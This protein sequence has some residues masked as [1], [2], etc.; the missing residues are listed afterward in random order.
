MPTFARLSDAELVMRM[1]LLEKHKTHQKAAQALGVSRSSFSTSVDNAKARGLTATTKL[2]N[3]EDRLRQK[4][5][6]A[7]AELAS[8][9]RENLSA[10]L[11]RKQIYE[12]AEMIPNPPLWAA[13][14]KKGHSSGIPMTMWSDWHYGEVVSKEE[15]GGVNVFN[16]AIGKQRVKQLVETTIDLCFN[17]MTQPK[18][19]GIVVCLGGDMISGTIHEELAETNDGPVQQSVLEVEELLIWGLTQIADKFGKVFVPCVVGNHGRIHKKPRA[20]RRVFESYEWNIYQHLERHFRSDKR[21]Q[22]M[23]PVDSD[24]HFT[25]AGHRFLLTHGDT[26]GVKGGDGIIGALGPIARGAIKVGRNQSQIGRDFDTLLIGHWH[27]YTPRSDGSRVIVNG[28]LKGY[29]E[30]AHTVLRASYAPPSQALWF[31]HPKH[32]VT[33]QWPI[34]LDEKRTS[35]NAPWVQWREAA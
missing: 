11:I 1:Q 23:V 29:D 34:Q 4:L 28:A 15:V 21:F 22:F 26:L 20:K 18:Y 14:L 33:C 19:P 8:I 25:V 32:G 13:G 30:Y 10:D 16:R 31:I 3:E 17:H 35:K 12:L 7:E 27:Q 5:K 9:H 6:L 2:K 24:A